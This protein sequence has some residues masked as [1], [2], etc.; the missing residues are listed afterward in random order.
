MLSFDTRDTFSDQDSPTCANYALRRTATDNDISYRDAELLS[1]RGFL[2][3]D[4]LDSMENSD[5]SLTR[6]QVVIEL[7]N[8]RGFKLT[9][10]VSN[11]QEI[12]ESCQKQ[13]QGKWLSAT[14]GK[15]TC[16]WFELEPCH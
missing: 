5:E 6:L 7:L 13:D 14:L 16:S 15:P 9:K 4:Y 11:V 2:M 8:K 12:T 1:K 3:D 10:C